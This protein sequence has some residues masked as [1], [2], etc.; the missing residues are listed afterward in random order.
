MVAQWLVDWPLELKVAGSISGIGKGI[1][2]S[3]HVFLCVICRDDMKT[4]CTSSDQD[5]N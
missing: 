3:E 5:V 1:L 2:V 4:V